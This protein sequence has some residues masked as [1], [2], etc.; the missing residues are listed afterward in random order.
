MLTHILALG[1]QNIP[2][3]DITMCV[4]TSS[5]M[6]RMQG[7]SYNR[8]RV[9]ARVTYSIWVGKTEIYL[10]KLGVGLIRD[11]MFEKIREEIKSELSHQ[12][13]VVTSCL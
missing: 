11:S 5:S 6:H 4:L 1:L 13:L 12:F 10:A 2:S 3:N 8:H 7:I 9:A